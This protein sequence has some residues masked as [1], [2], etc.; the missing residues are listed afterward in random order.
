MKLARTWAGFF[1]QKKLSGL[2]KKYRCQ[3]KYMIGI[4]MQDDQVI[5]FQS[6]TIC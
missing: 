5:Q 4:L 2:F 3:P 6:H 1:I